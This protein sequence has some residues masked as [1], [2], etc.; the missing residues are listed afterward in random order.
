MG[1]VKKSTKPKEEASGSNLENG[2]KN[3]VKL[4]TFESL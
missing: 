2:I 3:C 4:S 1:T